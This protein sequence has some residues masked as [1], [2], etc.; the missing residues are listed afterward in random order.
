MLADPEVIA[1]LTEGT[2]A[3]QLP[4]PATA[5][6]FRTTTTGQSDLY[7]VGPRTR[8]R[9][10][11]VKG[12]PVCV[13]LRLRPGVARAVLGVPVHALV[14]KTLPLTDLWGPA[15]AELTESLFAAGDD[16]PQVLTLMQAAVA[17]RIRGS[18]PARGFS[19][20]PIIDR[21]S[22][23]S[24]GGLLVA[25]V[26][27]MSTVPRL[28]DVAAGLGVSERHLRNLFAR[29]TGLSPKHYARITRVRRVLDQADATHTWAA[30]ADDA[31]FFDQAHMISDFRSFMGVTPAAYAA[32][33]LPP[34]TPCADLSR[35]P[36]STHS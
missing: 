12:V 24:A 23:M 21:T 36:D 5:L 33:R 2:T 27:A 19:T 31:G 9:Y 8:G 35:V 14:D 10:H 34:T 18:A 30:V 1:S 25:A 32:G 15:A 16:T 13:R 4:D 26:R 11:P 28:T 22:A 20:L 6:A 29:E 7:V 3:V 17:G